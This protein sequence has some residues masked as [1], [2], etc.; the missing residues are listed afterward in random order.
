M[1]NINFSVKTFDKDIKQSF[2]FP[3]GQFF[4]IS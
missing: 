1:T 4:F 2:I 3:Q